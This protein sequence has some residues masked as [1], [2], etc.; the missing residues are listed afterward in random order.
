MKY[1]KK[2]HKWIQLGDRVKGER[3]ADGSGWGS[4]LSRNGLLT[5]AIGAFKNDDGIGADDVGKDAG[6]TRWPYTHLHVQ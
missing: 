5:V 4:F 3:I 1:E 6:H 2:K